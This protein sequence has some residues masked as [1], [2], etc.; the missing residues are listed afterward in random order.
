MPVVRRYSNSEQVLV[1]AGASINIADGG[2]LL[3]DGQRV[4]A[5][6]QQ[7]SALSG[8]IDAAG[9]IRLVNTVWDDLRFPAAGINPPGAASDPARDTDDGRLVFSATLEN[10]IA[11]Q[12]QMPHQWKEGSTIHCHVHWGPTTAGAGNVRWQ[13]LYKVANINEA[14][15]AGW[16]TLVAT[17]AASGVAD[18]HQISPIGTIDMT[19]K[20]LSSMLLIKL[21]R[22]GADGLD[23]YAGTVKLNEFDIHFEIDGLGSGEEYVK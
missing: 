9:E 15:P 20:T 23:T 8:L 10:I 7:I 22:L 6:A 2:M 21:S 16:S 19:G 1:D 12:V 17:V 5:T 14:F 11:V 3:I 4:T 18:Q 13:L